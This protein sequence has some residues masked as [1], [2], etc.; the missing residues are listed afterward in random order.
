MGDVLG[1]FLQCVGHDL[2]ICLAMSW[3]CVGHALAMFWSCAGIATSSCRGCSTKSRRGSINN[4]H[5]AIQI[6]RAY[7]PLACGITRIQ[8]SIFLFIVGTPPA[9]KREARETVITT[10]STFERSGPR[11]FPILGR[12]FSDLDF[13]MEF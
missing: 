12:H 13:W 1:M 8:S 6:R 5:G 4:S 7:G 2:D 3:E 9:Q 11:F 10:F